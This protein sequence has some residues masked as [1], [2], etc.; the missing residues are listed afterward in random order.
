MRW[1][2]STSKFREDLCSLQLCYQGGS[3]ATSIPTH[4]VFAVSIS[5]VPLSLKI[6]KELT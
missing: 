4:A 1:V 6:N 5:S 2:H 3:S